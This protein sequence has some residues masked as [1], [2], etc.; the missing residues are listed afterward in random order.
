LIGASVNPK[1]PCARRIAGD[2]VNVIHFFLRAALA[3]YENPKTKMIG[4]AV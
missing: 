1:E 4:N 2:G 3:V